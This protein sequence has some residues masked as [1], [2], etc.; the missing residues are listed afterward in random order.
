MKVEPCMRVAGLRGASEPCAPL[1]G[2]VNF[3]VCQMCA[4]S[5]LNLCALERFICGWVLNKSCYSL[6]WG[7]Y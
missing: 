1:N 5:D 4:Y 3:H 7:E 2:D 6:A